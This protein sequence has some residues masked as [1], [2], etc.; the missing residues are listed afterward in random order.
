MKKSILIILSIT[1]LL[2]AWQLLAMLVRLPDLVPSVPRLLST[3]AALFASGS[4]YQSVM[5]TV[6][7]GT[8]GMSYLVNGGRRKSLSCSTMRVDV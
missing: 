5:A 4:F 3:L 1:I 8:I 6:L 7:R 2:L